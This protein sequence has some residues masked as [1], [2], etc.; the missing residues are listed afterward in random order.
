MC[1]YIHDIINCP[2]KLG[3]TQHEEL[4]K[5]VTVWVVDA[6]KLRSGDLFYR[7]LELFDKLGALDRWVD[8][9]I[10]LGVHRR[11]RVDADGVFGPFL[12]LGHF[13][14]WEL[15][16]VPSDV[17]WAIVINDKISVLVSP[18]VYFEPLFFVA[19]WL[20][21]FNALLFKHYCQILQPV[22]DII[23]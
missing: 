21:A 22:H 20:S 14:P 10:F 15:V 18:S 19:N 2:W 8:G 6:W 9:N 1:D 5:R 4:L 16:P 23:C 17:N 3:I 12:E 7:R 11:V 13:L